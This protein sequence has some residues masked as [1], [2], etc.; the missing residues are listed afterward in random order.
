[1]RVAVAL[2][3]RDASPP[4]S[5]TAVAI[6]V[7]RATST[8]AVALS[9]GASRVLPVAAI[10]D[11]LQLRRSHPTALLC[12]EREGRKIDG[13]DLGNS[14]FEYAP[15]LVRG[16]ELIFASTNGSLAMI[17]ARSARRRL[18]GSF[19]NARATLA[20][21]ER[22]HEIV[23]ICAGKLGRF[24]LEDAAFAGWLCA[25]LESRGATLVGEAARLARVLAPRFPDEIRGLVQGAS[26][27]RYLRRMGAEFARDV[28]FCASLDTVDRAF[29]I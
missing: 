22:E 8:L 6:D 5:S 21:V 7:L 11:A 15:E 10:D 2:T 9:N 25:A 18:I 24:S 19:L 3:P 23:L 27:A 17:A 28:E 26:H 1:M 4:G 16:R 29:E 12:G 20:A 14:P 13:F